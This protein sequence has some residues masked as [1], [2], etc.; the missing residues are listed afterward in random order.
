MQRNL[1]AGL[2]FLLAFALQLQMAVFGLGLLIFLAIPWE[3]WV[4]AMQGA[5]SALVPLGLGG[6]FLEPGSPAW[7]EAARTRNQHY[8]LRWEWYK[9]LGIVAPMFLFWWWGH[10]AQKRDAK[11]LGWFCR[12]LAIFGT[13]VLVIGSALVIPPVF[14]RL[15]PFQPMRMFT[16]IYIYMLLVGGGLLGEIFLRNVRWRWVVLFLPIAAGMYFAERAVFPG[17]PHIEY[18]GRTPRNDWVQA[19]LWIRTHTPNEA[20]F[21]LNPHYFEDKG[22]DERGFRAWA[23]RSMLADWGKDGGVASLFPDVAPRWQKEVHAR[24][25][26]KHFSSKDF[27]RLKQDFGVTW[28]LLE[29]SR[30]EGPAIAPD[31]LDCPYQNSL[32]YVCRIR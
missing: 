20:Y 6:Q 8:L 25:N 13:L 18:P 2:C 7:Q 14:E 24:D 17:S 19:F 16:F 12:R 28:V 23:E 15:T 29:R 32:V 4:P 21:A 11:V 9:W 1:F 5:L 10:V 26:W 30:A 22:E 27:T 31:V 3:R